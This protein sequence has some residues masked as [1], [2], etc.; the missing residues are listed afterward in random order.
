MKILIH[1]LFAHPY[2]VYIVFALLLALIGSF[3][4]GLIRFQNE[5]RN[6]F[7]NMFSKSPTVDATKFVAVVGS[8]LVVITACV[9]VIVC[10]YKDVG[11]PGGSAEVLGSLLFFLQGGNAARA[12]IGNKS[13][14]SNPPAD[15]KGSIT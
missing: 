3:V 2:A 15:L 10:A 1:N 8:L 4:V 11:L 5:L 9:L 13:P 7:G 14:G 6:F 12:W